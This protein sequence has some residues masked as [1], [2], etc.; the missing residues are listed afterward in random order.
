VIEEKEQ[1][2]REKART[3][4]PAQPRAGGSSARPVEAGPIT[5]AAQE[6]PADVADT[7]PSGTRPVKL[8]R[9]LTLTVEV[10]DLPPGGRVP[11][12]HHGGPTLDYV[13]SGAVRMQMQDGPALDYYAGQT[14]FEPAGSVHVLTENLSGTRPA[15]IMLIHVADDGAE[16]VVFH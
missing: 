12:H 8:A 1:T 16:L 15:R 4:V 6:K 9:S 13:L 11:E 7:T 2:I 5:I 14:M 10:A 3:D